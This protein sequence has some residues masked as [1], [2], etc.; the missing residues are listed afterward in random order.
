M[1]YDPHAWTD[2]PGLVPFY[3]EKRCRPED[4]YP[5]ERRFLPWLAGQSDSVL[6]V[7][8]AAG[9]FRNIWRHYQLSIIYTGVDVSGPLIE[10]ARSLH[11]DC[12][13]HVGD[14]ANGFALEDRHSTV[15]QALGWLH[16]DPRYLEAIRELW[17]L[18]GRY[19]F[20][21][22]RLA[23]QPEHSVQGKQLLAYT[24]FG[25]D[26]STVPYLVVAWPPLASLLLDLEPVSIF[27]YGYWGK[28]AE[29]VIGVEG[30][31]CF[32]TFVLEKAAA[33]KRP[34][35]PTVILDM[36]LA[37]PPKKTD[38]VRLRPPSD[39]ASVA[40]AVNQGP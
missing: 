27:G 38:R 7:G 39:L 6:D 22:V 17:R 30:Q 19:L 23:S 15:V 25:D 11:P 18:T 35:P 29:T 4:L 20:F 8:C 32:V 33:E 1:S 36:P 26:G 24:G 13:F 9:G 40:P 16:W 14:C 5:S 21:D 2:H 31:V 37:W 3:T 10:A 34:G 12:Q 28:A